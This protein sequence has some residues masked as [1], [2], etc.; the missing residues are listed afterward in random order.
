MQPSERLAVLA[1]ARS[2]LEERDLSRAWLARQLGRSPSTVGKIL[3][4]DWP[5]KD[6]GNWPLY[7]DRWL[8]EVGLNPEGA[9]QHYILVVGDTPLPEYSVQLTA[10]AAERRNERR[11][12]EGRRGHWVLHQAADPLVDL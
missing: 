4:G 10:A 5:W 6:A 2:W 3:R 12:A 8:S 9:L 11:K 7:F 1:Q